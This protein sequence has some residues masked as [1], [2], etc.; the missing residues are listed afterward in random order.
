MRTTDV[1]KNSFDVVIVGGG[2][3]GAVLANRLSE[4]RARRVVLLEAGPVYV[5]AR[6]PDVIANANH[7]GGDPA[8]DWGTTARTMSASDMTSRRHGERFWAAVRP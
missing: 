6:Y 5:P 1:P 2:S 3:A 7:V 8:H 4:D